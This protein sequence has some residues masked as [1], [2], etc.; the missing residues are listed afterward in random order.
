MN[1]GLFRAMAER[2]QM[3]IKGKVSTVLYI[4]AAQAITLVLDTIRGVHTA[5]VLLPGMLFL[6]V[7][8][9]VMAL[10]EWVTLER[11][12]ARMVGRDLQEHK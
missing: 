8:I 1:D 3:R 12:V 6:G 10:H 2:E 4:P 7:I 5:D 11:R 9:L